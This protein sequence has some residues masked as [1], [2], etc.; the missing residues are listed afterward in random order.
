MTPERT[1]A[2]PKAAAR[3]PARRKPKDPAAEA[4][5]WVRQLAKKRPDLV[6]FILE[7]LGAEYGRPTWAPRLTPTS[8]LILTILTANSADVNAEVAF[9]RLRDRWPSAPTGRPSRSR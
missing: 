5:A 8:E 2:K 1:A 3:K 4:R 9:A 6:S 7:R